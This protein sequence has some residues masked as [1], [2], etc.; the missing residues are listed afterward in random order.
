MRTYDIQDQESYH[1]TIIG[2]FHRRM[3]LLFHPDRRA[4]QPLFCTFEEPC[5]G[6]PQMGR[7]EPRL[8][9]RYLDDLVSS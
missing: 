4:S 6:D 7:R 1:E 3:G 2:T 9:K 5:T 8:E